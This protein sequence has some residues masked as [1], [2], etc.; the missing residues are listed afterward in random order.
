[1]ARKLRVEYVGAIHH[2]VNRGNGRE[3]FFAEDSDRHRFLETVGK[4]SVKMGWQVH[5]DVL[6]P[7]LF[8]R[9]FETPQPNLV[10]G[11]KW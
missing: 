3:M 8:H 4:A 10:A 5:A 2:L 1:M 6:M 7:S 9:E 11:I